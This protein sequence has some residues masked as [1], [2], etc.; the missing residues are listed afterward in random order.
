MTCIIV[1]T[2]FL[3]LFSYFFLST[4]LDNKRQIFMK[5]FLTTSRAWWILTHWRWVSHWRV[6]CAS[7]SCIRRHWGSTC[8]Y[9][10]WGEA[11]R[12]TICWIRITSAIRWWE[13]CLEVDTWDQWVGMA[14]PGV[15]TARAVPGVDKAVPGVD[16]AVQQVDKAVPQVGMVHLDRL[17]S[18]L[19]A[20]VGHQKKCR[21]LPHLNKLLCMQF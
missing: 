15:G 9:I 17:V 4:E 7:S 14:V 10:V 18:W 6:W 13:G 20:F 21:L 16:K 1:R 11:S 2:Y 3:F 19:V 5:K 12:G 8:S